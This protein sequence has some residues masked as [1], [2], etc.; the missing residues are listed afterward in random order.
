MTKYDP[1]IHHR[2]STRLP[3]YDYASAGSTFVTICVH[4]GECLLGEVIDDQMRLSDF[5]QVVAH[6]WQCIP[7]H[8][9]LVDLDAWV[10]MPNQMHGILTIV[11]SVDGVGALADRGGQEPAGSEQA[12]ETPR[13]ARPPPVGIGIIGRHR[14]QLQVDHRTAHQSHAAYTLSILLAAQLLGHR[15]P[16]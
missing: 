6:Y 7:R 16:Q 5:G 1:R 8:I 9:S 10:I 3:R 14:R 4:G 13:H 11:A 12:K 15:H 2:R